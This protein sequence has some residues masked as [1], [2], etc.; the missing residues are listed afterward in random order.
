V[1]EVEESQAIAGA[2]AFGWAGIRMLVD[3]RTPAGWA[4]LRNAF[5]PQRIGDS[6]IQK[7][8][9]E[10]TGGTSGTTGSQSYPAGWVR[11][12]EVAFSPQMARAKEV[13]VSLGV[14]CPTLT[15]RFYRACIPS[16]KRYI[17]HAHLVWAARLGE[18]PGLSLNAIA[19]RLDASSPQSFGRS[20]RT[21]VGVTAANFRRQ[22]DGEAMLARFRTDLIEPYRAKLQTFDPLSASN[23]YQRGQLTRSRVGEN[24]LRVSG[25][26]G[27]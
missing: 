27:R 13:A 26:A 19:D 15:S 17:A 21:L 2:L 6:F 20:V 1:S 9:R 24:Q 10:L 5:D 11:F 14:P 25:R 7:A 16:P 23:A 3:V 8:L 4:A 22:F 12:L 18:T